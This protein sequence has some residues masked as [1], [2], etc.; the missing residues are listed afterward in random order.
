VI[1]TAPHATRPFR[2]GQYRF[3][4]GGGTAAL[5]NALHET[6]GV[7]AIFTVYESPSDPNFYDDNDFKLTVRRIIDNEHPRLLLDI[8]ASAPERPYDV[9]LGT[10]NGLSLMGQLSIRDDLVAVLRRNGV[11][12]ISID[13]FSAARNG[14]ITKFASSLGVPAVQ[15]EINSAWLVPGRSELSTRRFGVLVRALTAYLRSTFPLP[16]MAGRDEEYACR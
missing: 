9:D 14:T 6:A 4:D 3:S 15:L 12:T 11:R 2:Q 10:M 8:H 1:V 7:T 5:A 13:F 16:Q